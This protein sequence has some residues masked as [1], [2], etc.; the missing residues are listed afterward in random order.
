MAYARRT[1][2]AERGQRQR[3]EQ[4]VPA[5]VGGALRQL[6]HHA[7]GRPAGRQQ[8]RHGAGLEAGIG[9]TG[10]GLV[11]RHKAGEL[12][13][14]LEFQRQGEHLRTH[15]ILIR[16]VGERVHPVVDLLPRPQHADA[17]AGVGVVD[18]QRA[19]PADVTRITTQ[20]HFAT[21]GAVNRRGHHHRLTEVEIGQRIG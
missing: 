8:A 13:D 17:F 1:G 10:G 4:R 3:T 11:D 19:G 21:H 18:R 20:A 15:R 5:R 12:A 6:A 16:T 14:Q 2:E 7:R 9:G